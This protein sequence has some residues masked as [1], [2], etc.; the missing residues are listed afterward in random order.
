MEQQALP[1]PTALLKPFSYVLFSSHFPEPVFGVRCGKQSLWGGVERAQACS[2]VDFWTDK[3]GWCWFI[4]KEKYCWLTDK[5]WLKPINKQAANPTRWNLC[6]E[7]AAEA[8]ATRIDDRLDGCVIWNRIFCKIALASKKFYTICSKKLSLSFFFSLKWIKAS[9]TRKL[10]S[11]ALTPLG[12]IAKGR[13]RETL[14]NR[15]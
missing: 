8:A 11:L 10:P 7:G 1:A 15:P 6:D 13:P 4:V 12:I 3:V 9:E 14:P 5:F 2:L